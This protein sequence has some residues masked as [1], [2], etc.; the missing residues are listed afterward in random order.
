MYGTKVS[1]DAD[2]KFIDENLPH[3]VYNRFRGMVKEN[4]G[5]A[6]SVDIRKVDKFQQIYYESKIEHVRV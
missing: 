4:I 6:K 5:N 2:A 1:D 3:F